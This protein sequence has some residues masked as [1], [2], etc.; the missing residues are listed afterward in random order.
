MFGFSYH[1]Q[2]TFTRISFFQA[3]EITAGDIF[4]LKHTRTWEFNETFPVR[5]VAFPYVFTGF[6]FYM[7]KLVFGVGAITSTALTVAPRL[8]ISTATLLVDLSVY[9]ICRHL[10]IDPAPSLCLFATSF[11]TLVFYTRTFS[12]T[13]E[14]LLFALLLQ[15]V[16]SAIAN[17]D[18]LLSR[19]DRL[20]YFAIGVVVCAG[21]WIRPTFVTF[22]VVPWVV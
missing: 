11:V 21:I 12:N 6:P 19:K 5:S 3:T 4:G 2:A 17:I 18:T 16:V 22:A 1:K 7:L 15:L 10:R 8:W 20:R 9:K 13:A 14:A